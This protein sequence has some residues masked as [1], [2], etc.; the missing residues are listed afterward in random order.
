M[1]RKLAL[2]LLMLTLPIQAWAVSDMQFKYQP[3]KMGIKT[4]APSHSCH[5]N[6]KISTADYS[7]LENQSED[8]SCNSCIFCM[9]YALYSHPSFISELSYALTFNVSNTSFASYVTPSLNKP[10]I[11]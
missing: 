3:S 9:G 8:G 10:P 2:I 4:Q 7:L 1:L 6:V 11:L 5:Q